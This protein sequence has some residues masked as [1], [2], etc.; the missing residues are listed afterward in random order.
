MTVKELIEELK[1]MPQETEFD[2][3]INENDGTECVYQNDISGV[4]TVGALWQKERY[5]KK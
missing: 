1:K 2:I 4:V 5:G 3:D